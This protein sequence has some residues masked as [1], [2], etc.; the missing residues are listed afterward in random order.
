MNRTAIFLAS[1]A[2]LALV[3]LVVGMPRPMNLVAPPTPVA[4]SSPPQAFANDGSIK[5]TAR[6]SHPYVGS[7]RSEAFVTV[8]LNGVEVPGQ[9]RTPVNLALVI[10][11]SGSMSGFKLQQAKM[12]ALQLVS[13]LKATDRLA[14]V[15][16]GGDVKSMNG[17]FCTEE[18]KRS[19]IRYI[20]NIWDEGGTNIGAGLTTGR[21][22]L[23][24][25][26]SDF[27]VNRLVL[28][29]DGQPTEGL[30]DSGSLLELTRAI[31]GAGISVTSI[32]VGTDFNEDLMQGIAASGGGAYAFL[33]DAAQLSTIFQKD[34]N[35]AGTQVAHDVLLSFKLP[36]GVELDEVLGYRSGVTDRRQV[37]VSLPDFSAGQFERLVA[38]VTIT[39]PAAGLAFDVAG[40]SLDYVDL[41]QGKPV[42]SR[43]SLA[44]MSTDRAD[45]VFAKRDKDATVYAARAQSAVNTQ[46]AADALKAGDRARAQALL[47]Q[48]AFFFEEAGK[49][50]GEG[51]VAQ[52]RAEQ[53][54]WNEQFQKATS[55]DEVQAASKGAKRKA[56]LDF[57]LQGST[58]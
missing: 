57:G 49:V 54:Q 25:S 38:R 40:L 20:D 24:A 14:I 3:A 16:Y 45:V 44:A 19:L 27:K 1:A 51:A 6:L 9:S 56:R 58:Y 50:A 55:D 37:T 11:R 12:A 42:H 7:G 52:D 33:Q 22:L 39:A 26:M 28:I 32:G 41:L 4:N 47:Q 13:Q 15:H 8:D 29:S 5:M 35:Q 43:A 2:V 10:D 17:V 23:L 34:L 18:N 53:K 30:Q 21:D 36:E 31:R 48:N 46:A